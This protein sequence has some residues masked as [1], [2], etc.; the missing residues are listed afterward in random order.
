MKIALIFGSTGQD[1]SYM[2]DLLIKKI[3]KFMDW[4]GNQLLEIQ[5]I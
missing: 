2:C 3:I 4:L 1:G 5:E